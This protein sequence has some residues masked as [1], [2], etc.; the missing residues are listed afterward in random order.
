MVPLS[1]DDEAAE[2]EAIRD[3]VKKR[4]RPVNQVRVPK[5]VEQRNIRGSADSRSVVS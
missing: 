1:R 2:V 3:F 4:A 5:A